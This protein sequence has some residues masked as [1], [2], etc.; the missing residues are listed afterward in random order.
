[1]KCSAP[2]LFHTTSLIILKPENLSLT[3]VQPG[4]WLTHSQS[5]QW[6]FTEHLRLRRCR[7]DLEILM[8]G[9]RSKGPT[10]NELKEVARGRSKF[11]L[12]DREPWEQKWISKGDLCPWANC[13]FW[14]SANLGL[15]PSSLWISCVALGELNYISGPQF[16]PLWD[17]Y[18]TLS[19]KIIV[20][21]KRVIYNKEHDPISG[22]C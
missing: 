21:M 9:N 17:G 3:W 4:S 19:H 5:I 18:H 12:K 16:L 11:L 10:V 20:R 2:C 7:G 15:F 6:I 13:E 8:E 22:T 14:G 1:M